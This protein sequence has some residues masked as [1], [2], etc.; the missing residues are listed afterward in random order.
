M[1]RKNLGTQWRTVYLH[2]LGRDVPPMKRNY[3]TLEDLEGDPLPRQED[4]EEEEAKLERG[5]HP[6]L[7]RTFIGIRHRPQ[8]GLQTT[9]SGQKTAQKRSN[10]EEQPPSLEQKNRKWKGRRTVPTT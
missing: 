2:T 6:T 1:L 4:I 8:N 9:R 5:T 10:S 3:V 7:K